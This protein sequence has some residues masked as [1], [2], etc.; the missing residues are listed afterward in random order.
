MECGR[1][2]AV[3]GDNGLGMGSGWGCQTAGMVF[4]LSWL[5]KEAKIEWGSE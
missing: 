4:Y 2:E 3:P 5:E 1:I